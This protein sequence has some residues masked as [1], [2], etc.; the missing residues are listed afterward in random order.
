MGWLEF[1]Y[2]LPAKLALLIPDGNSA[3]GRAQLLHCLTPRKSEC[4]WSPP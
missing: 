1:V 2:I 4:I 3:L